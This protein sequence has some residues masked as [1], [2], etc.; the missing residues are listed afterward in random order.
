MAIKSRGYSAEFSLYGWMDHLL[1]SLLLV[2]MAVAVWKPSYID[3]SLR[4][5]DKEFLSYGY[6]Y[7]FWNNPIKVREKTKFIFRYYLHT[8]YLIIGPRYVRLIVILY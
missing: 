2:S 6:G 5:C 1:V 7:L 4:T 8:V 3:K